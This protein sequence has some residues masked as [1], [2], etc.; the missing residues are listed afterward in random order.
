MRLKKARA[1]AV[2][3]VAAGADLSLKKWHINFIS[4]SLSI[5][6]DIF[7]SIT[8]RLHEKI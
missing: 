7:L 4:G 3:G 1:A 6:P 8:R 5:C 2:A